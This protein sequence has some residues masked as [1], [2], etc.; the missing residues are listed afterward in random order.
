MF[1]IPFKVCLRYT[2]NYFAVCSLLKSSQTV[3]FNFIYCSE[4]V[5]KMSSARH[6]T[7]SYLSF[8]NVL[9]FREIDDQLDNKIV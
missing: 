2:Q 6:A 3:E 1:W 4:V 9:I 8:R 7:E 5:V